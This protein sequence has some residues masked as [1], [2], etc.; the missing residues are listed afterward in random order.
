MAA[1]VIETNGMVPFARLASRVNTAWWE[2]PEYHGQALTDNSTLEEWAA[3]CGFEWEIVKNPVEYW[4]GE[5]MR[6]MKDKFVLHRSDNG[7]ALA[8]ASARWSPV[9][10][11]E[12]LD[13]FRDVIREQGWKMLTAGVLLEGAKFWAMA[14]VPTDLRVGPLA[15]KAHVCFS[16]GADLKTATV[17]K[18]VST[19]VVCNNTLDAALGEKG[20]EVRVR[21]TEVWDP[22]KAKDSLGV[23]HFEGAWDTFQE[24]MAR[25][26]ETPIDRDQATQI[27]KDLLR[28]PKE[29]REDLGAHSFSDLLSGPVKTAAIKSEI[30]ADPRGL[31]PL[32]NAYRTA[33]GALPG[34]AL[35]VLQAVTYTVDHTRGS[36]ANRLNSAWFGSGATMKANA[37]K[38]LAAL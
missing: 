2:T 32:L 16:T 7:K 21:H 4:F 12:V 33:P 28:P 17:V 30:E 36:D 20:D 1:N 22:K 15:A 8:V 13:F 23:L 10:P 25:L 24:E 29:R 11:K 14:E 3:A 38:A 35:G 19:V 6:T 37:V 26:Y 31:Q 34:T 5:E 18:P 9:Q 27:F